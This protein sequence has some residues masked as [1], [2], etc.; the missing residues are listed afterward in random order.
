MVFLAQCC[1]CELSG[2]DSRIVPV[3]LW[4]TASS[5]FAVFLLFLFQ[6]VYKW[7]YK[8]DFKIHLEC[9]TS[10][11]WQIQ[12]LCGFPRDYE[13]VIGQVQE[14]LRHVN[15]MFR[16]LPPLALLAFPQRIWEK[17]LICTI[18]YD[19]KIVCNLSKDTTLGFADETEWDERLKRL[20]KY[21]YKCEIFQ[22]WNTSTVSAQ[23][24]LL[25]H[26]INGASLKEALPKLSNVRNMGEDFWADIENT[27][28]DNRS[29]KEATDATRPFSDIGQCGLMRN[30]YQ[31]WLREIKGIG[32]FDRWWRMK[33]RILWWGK[34]IGIGSNNRNMP[35]R[36]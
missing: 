12:N 21:F 23:L 33:V 35:P 24:E 17:R 3:I 10:A 13:L 9:A 27:F 30:E 28:I 7:N 18:L 4:G 11:M 36:D 6:R 16:S 34:K 32:R 5:I 31:E 14:L 22:K 15:G 29:F 1:V 25:G 2:P 26:L 19:I 8:R 20:R